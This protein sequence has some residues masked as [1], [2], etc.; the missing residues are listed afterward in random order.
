MSKVWFITGTST[1]LGRTLV[2]EVVRR[3]ER[4]VATVRKEGTHSDLV[5]KALSRVK[6]LTRTSLH[7]LMIMVF[8]HAHYERIAESFFFSLLN[9][10]SKATVDG[11]KSVR[12]TKARAS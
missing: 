2:E 6:I 9:A 10:A 11:V 12:R 7:A 5:E 4:L 1:G 8:R 3:G